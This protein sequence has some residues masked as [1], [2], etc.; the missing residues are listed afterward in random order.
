VIA[1]VVDDDGDADIGQE[2]VAEAAKEQQ[3]QAPVDGAG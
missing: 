3:E 1:Q 2:R